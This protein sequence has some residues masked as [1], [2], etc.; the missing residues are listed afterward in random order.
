L[1]AGGT[2]IAGSHLSA[3]TGEGLTERELRQWLN[4]EAAGLGPRQCLAFT[5][6]TRCP[7][8][9][10]RLWSQRGAAWV[11]PSGLNDYPSARR[12]GHWQPLPSGP[13]LPSWMA[14][15][16]TPWSNG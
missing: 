15:D 9:P 6:A 13:V 12:A 14:A 1:I 2:C 16:V 4:D 5:W 10:Y 11:E 7:G 8:W 3:P